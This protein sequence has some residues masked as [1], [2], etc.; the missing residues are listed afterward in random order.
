MNKITCI[1]I[2]SIIIGMDDIY[3]I[4]QLYDNDE[5]HIVIDIDSDNG[6]ANPVP[7]KCQAIQNYIG[8]NDDMDMGMG[9]D[10]NMDNIDNDLAAVPDVSTPVSNNN[11]IL[12]I[13][14]YKKSFAFKLRLL[15]DTI[16]FDPYEQTIDNIHFSE[17]I[18]RSGLNN[19]YN[20]CDLMTFINYLNVYNYCIGCR[21]KLD[22]QANSYVAC[23]NMKCVYKTEELIIDNVVVDKF[24]ANAE[25]CKFLIE[26]AIDA[27]DCPRRNDIFE[28]FPTYFLKDK[29]LDVAER[30]TMSKIN[31]VNHDN[32]KDFDKLKS[33]LGGFNIHKFETLASN[34]KSDIELSEIIGKDLYILI[35]FILMSIRVHIH[36][37][38]QMLG[39][40]SDKFTIYKITHEKDKEEE[41][42]MT[43]QNKR[44]HYVF[45]GSKWHNWYSILRNGL[46]NCSNTPLMTCGAAYGNG[47]YT[48][49]DI[50]VSLRY[51]MSGNIAA[52]G[53]FEIVDKELYKKSNAIYVI[54]NDKMLIQRYLLLVPSSSQNQ[55]VKEINN[56]FNKTIYEVKDVVNKQYSKKSRNKIMMEYKRITKTPDPNLKYDIDVDP[57]N[58]YIWLIRLKNPGQGK[59]SD[60]M[61]KYDINQIEIEIRFPDNYPFSP[62]FLRVVGPRFLHLTGHITISGSWCNELLTEKGWS[63]ACSIDTIIAVFITELLEG[64]GRIDPLK[65]HVKYTYEEAKADFIR[66]AR[67]HGWL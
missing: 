42:T 58:I 56:T 3:S 33:T 41:F 51:G 43:A 14:L 31:S 9:M 22:F 23:G 26:S 4:I 6:Q 55:F 25:I 24:K 10:M 17:I 57:D 45:H 18:A 29:T 35:R 46:K 1:F 49:D 44:S 36:R 16:L 48:S 12:R 47:I 40:T 38:D 50:N 64:G 63:P 32:N 28:P 59:V 62:P 15:N 5:M 11:Q 66:V 60:D 27:I 65:Y 54:D 34:A 7:A 20:I 19:S 52:I 67:S 13:N 30:G 2:H 8:E 37:N 39:L 21:T 53:V 61:I